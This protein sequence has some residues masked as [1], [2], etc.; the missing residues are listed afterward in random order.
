VDFLRAL[1]IT[2]VIFGHGLIAALWMIGAFGTRWR[3]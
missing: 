1:S 2:A 3:T